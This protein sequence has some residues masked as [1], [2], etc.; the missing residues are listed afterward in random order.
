MEQGK[1]WQNLPMPRRSRFDGYVPVYRGVRDVSHEDVVN[2][3]R[4]VGSH[5]SSSRDVA[6]TFA[7]MGSFDSRHRTI[8]P[9]NGSN[10]KSTVLHG[11]VHPDHV[12]SREEV[13]KWNLERPQKG[14]HTKESGES[15]VSIRPGSPVHLIG[16]TDYHW[17]GESRFP[18][19]DEVS[20]KFAAPIE[21]TA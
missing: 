19:A 20:H 3:A 12:M 13:N 5:W 10:I 2:S 17:D 7:N 1:Q 4:R 21:K 18:T 11:F 15:E 9:D 14:I 16:A 8:D 6:E